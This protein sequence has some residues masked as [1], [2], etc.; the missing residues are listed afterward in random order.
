MPSE[1]WPITRE[2]TAGSHGQRRLG[3]RNALVT[4]RTNGLA[5]ELG[6]IGHRNLGSPARRKTKVGKRSNAPAGFS[7]DATRRVQKTNVAGTSGDP[8]KAG[9]APLPYLSSR[10]R[11]KQATEAV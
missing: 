6:G 4:F 10:S 8:G 11:Q 5:K 9:P 1:I 7:T 3:A 2:G